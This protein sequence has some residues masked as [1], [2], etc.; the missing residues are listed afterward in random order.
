MSNAALD[1]TIRLLT[2]HEFN[3]P[4]NGIMGFAQLAKM[5]IEGSIGLQAKE[6]LQCIDYIIKSAERLNSLMERLRLWRSIEE[7]NLLEK[8]DFVEVDNLWI[9][10]LFLS[11][12]K[13]KYPFANIE[14]KVICNNPLY[15]SNFWGSRFLFKSA[16]AEVLDNA[17]KFTHN[18]APVFVEICQDVNEKYTLIRVSNSCNKDI[19]AELLNTYTPYSQF[20]R[21]KYEQQGIGLGLAIA[22]KALFLN[23]CKLNF[24]QKD[25]GEITANISIPFL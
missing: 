4:L 11:L 20:F 13:N 22:R 14:S 24:L 8:G 16:F 17:F 9:D 19:N 12:K 1:N 10:D 7:L 23:G 15:K 2:G 3:T 25:S 5:E 6:S 21:D 18:N